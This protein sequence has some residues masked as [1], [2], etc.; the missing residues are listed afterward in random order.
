[1]SNTFEQAGSG[2]ERLGGAITRYADWILAVGVLGLV[3]TIIG[4]IQMATR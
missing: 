1:M 4:A 3:L 2:M